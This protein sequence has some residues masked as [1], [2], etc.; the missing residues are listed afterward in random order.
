MHRHGLAAA[1]AAKPE[2]FCLRGPDSPSFKG[3]RTPRLD[4][5][6]GAGVVGHHVRTGGGGGPRP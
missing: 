6:G 1:A 4:S 3:A 2:S 5:R